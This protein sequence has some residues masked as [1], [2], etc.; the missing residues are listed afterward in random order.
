MEA[1]G[2]NFK[3]NWSSLLAWWVK[4]LTLSLQWFGFLLWCRFEPWSGN[5]HMP[6]AQQK[7]K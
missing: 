3:T 7:I 2:L 5:F 6:C 4:D 1:R